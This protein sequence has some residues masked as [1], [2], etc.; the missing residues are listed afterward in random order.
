MIISNSSIHDVHV[1]QFLLYNKLTTYKD[2]F[3]FHQN[4]IAVDILYVNHS[5]IIL[6]SSSR[7]LVQDYTDTKQNY[8]KDTINTY[9]KLMIDNKYIYLLIQTK[10]H[11]LLICFLISFSS[12]YR[13]INDM[14][15]LTDSKFR[16]YLSDIYRSKLE[17]KDT[18]ASALYNNM[19]YECH[20]KTDL[21]SLKMDF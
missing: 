4:F 11:Y 2:Y 13:Y 17:V 12:T 10:C 19:Y 15:S 3:Q 14:T 20:F 5:M 7:I 18:T 1:S 21:F 6:N 8:T 9:L 16:D